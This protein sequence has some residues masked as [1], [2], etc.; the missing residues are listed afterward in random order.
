MYLLVTL[1]I[2]LSM[3]QGAQDLAQRKKNSSIRRQWLPAKD[4]L[5][6]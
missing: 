5:Q 4:L 2:K 1:L 3:L 6:L